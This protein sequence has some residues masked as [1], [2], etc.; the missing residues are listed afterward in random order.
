MLKLLRITYEDKKPLEAEVARWD[1]DTDSE[2][3]AGIQLQATQAGQ[4]RLSYQL[5]DK[6]AHVIEGG[7]IFTVRG[8][9]DDGERYRFAKIELVPGQTGLCP[10]GAR[11]P[12]D[13]YRL[14]RGLPSFFLSVRP[15]VFICHP[16]LS[17]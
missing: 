14:S 12:H 9:G 10:G 15:M 13:Q 4:Y 16:K 17:T 5:T 7:Y 8:E 3:R 11:S 6:K 1:L 2:G